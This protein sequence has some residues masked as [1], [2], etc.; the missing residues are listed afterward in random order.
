MSDRTE[1]L[2]RSEELAREQSLT[3]L[4][5]ALGDRE[6]LAG[7]RVQVRIDHEQ[8]AQDEQRLGETLAGP[9]SEARLDDSQARIDREQLNRDVHQ[10]TLDRAQEGRDT[11]QEALDHT[12][13]SCRACPR[14]SSRPAPIRRPSAAAAWSAPWPPG[15]EPSPRWCGPRPRSLEPMHSW[16]GSRGP[17]LNRGRRHLMPAADSAA[18]VAQALDA[19]LRARAPG[20]QATTELV[21]RLV[22]RMGRELGFGQPAEELLESAARVRDIGMLALPDS[23]V[24][25]TTRLSPSEWALIN[26]HPI[27][28][29]ELLEGLEALNSAAPIIRWH[30]ER[31]DGRGYPDGLVG[32]AIP[33]MSR[34][35]AIC[36]AFVAVASDRPHRRGMGAA[37][38]AELL[39]H[40]SGQQFDPAMVDTLGACLANDTARRAAP[41]YRA[42][43]GLGRPSVVPETPGAAGFKRAVLD[44]D[45][46]PVLAPA[47]ERLMSQI[48]SQAATSGDLVSTIESDI[49]LTVA[50]LRLAQRQAGRRPVS[51]VPDAVVALDAAGIA[52]AARALPRA[53]FP[54]RTSGLEVLMHSCLVHA[55]AVARAADRLARELNLPD[56]DEILVA[57][58][59]HDVGKL[60]LH[61]AL[62]GYSADGN[63]KMAPEERVRQ[64]QLAWGMDHAS[65]GGL[66]LGRW[67]LAE[68]IVTNVARHHSADGPRDIATYVRLADMLAHHAQGHAVDRSTLLSLAAV[69]ELSTHALREILFDLPHAGA[70]TRRRAEPSPLS[71]R[72]TDVLVLL[73]QGL[74][75]KQI[76]LELGVAASTVRSHIHAIYVA[77]G[78]DDRAQAV[79][80][81]TEMGWM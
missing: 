4:E 33:L 29:A 81:A 73:A 10:E 59:L 39:R 52:E 20:I 54:W 22:A 72:Q 34:V 61:R 36:D 66:L 6:Q 75:Y 65:I 70:S 11:Q 23:M 15:S 76:A 18:P 27:L 50:V 68:Q 14:G 48:D 77:L 19:A 3:E 31:W 37:A 16:R 56:R 42:G 9:G 24:L 28:G 26:R 80:R 74:H 55:Q 44:F 35:I 43:G 64:E 25:T 53:E 79:L 41:E 57:A 8:R 47:V 62:A 69:C 51:N 13:V 67:S 1:R 17:R 30:H 2:A 60:A 21:V 40:E 12:R 38:A 5:Q 63:T 46:V 58:L 49:G 7:D 71:G 45:V 32:E 78:V